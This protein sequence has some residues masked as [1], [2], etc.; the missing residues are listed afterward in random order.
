MDIRVYYEDTDAAGIVY[1][2]NYLRFFERA[3]TEYLRERGLSVSELAA[4]G[5]VFPVIRMEIDL[6]APA[7]HDDLLVVVTRPVRCGKSSFTLCQQILRKLDGRLL[8]DS[9][10]TL[11]CIGENLR[12]KRIPEEVRQVLDQELTAAGGPV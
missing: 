1:H 4:K 3:R 2:A 8:V 7:R 6:K 11:A 12:A 5:Q 10:I 9:L